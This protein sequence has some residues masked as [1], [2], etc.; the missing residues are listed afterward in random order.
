MLEYAKPNGKIDV[1]RR[2]LEDFKEFEDV[3]IVSVYVTNS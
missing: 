3:D 1:G 2:C